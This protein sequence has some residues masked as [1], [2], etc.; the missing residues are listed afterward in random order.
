MAGRCFTELAMPLRAEP[1]LT[2]VLASYDA[3]R[4]R[5]RSLYLT[6][7]A[8]TYVHARE[9]EQAATVAGEA[10][11]LAERVNSPRSRDRVQQVGEHLAPYRRAAAVR[12]FEERLSHT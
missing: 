3:A 10:L 8:D 4:A 12:D 5:E 1:L 2:S 7:L 11:D 6:W 9:I